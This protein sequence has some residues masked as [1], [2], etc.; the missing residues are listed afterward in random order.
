MT[1]VQTLEK[2]VSARFGKRDESPTKQK[3]NLPPSAVAGPD[4][5]ND[6]ESVSPVEDLE[7]I[8]KLPTKTY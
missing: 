2:E 7:E 6:D 3:E 1:P 4:S 5:D 8:G